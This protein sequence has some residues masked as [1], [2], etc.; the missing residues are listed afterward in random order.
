MSSEYILQRDLK[1]NLHTAVKGEGV[2]IYDESG[3]KYLDGS[4]GAA[5][6][7]LGHSNQKVKDAII[8]Q[9]RSLPYAH[10]SFFTSKPAEELAKMLIQRAP[11]NMGK[12]YFLSGGTEA[13]ET[14]F[15]LIRQY[16]IENKEPQRVHIIARRQSYHGNTITALSVGGN[17]KRK[18]SFLP[19]MS[20]YMHH[21]D[22]VYAYRLKKDDETLEEYGIRAANLLEEKILELGKDS[23]AAFVYEPLVGST[24]GAVAAPLSY[25]KKIREICDKYGVLLMSDEIMCGYGRTGYLFTS[26][27][28]GVKPDLITLAKGIGAGYQP[29]AATLVSKKIYDAI[30]NG[31]G[32]FSHG[33]TYVGHPCSTA[34]GV[35]VLKEIEDNNLLDNVRKMG[36][37]LKGK[38]KSRFASHPYVGDIRG[39]GLFVGVELVKNKETKECFDP[40]LKLFGQIKQTAKDLG[41][42]CYPMGG[43]NFGKEGDHILLAPPFIINE[44][45]IVELIDKL[46]KAINRSLEI[47]GIA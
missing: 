43:T 24:L 41:L 38:L 35:A 6:S 46:E 36:K 9:L 27:Y 8:D 7:C 19:Y 34:A 11:N 20:K 45:Q 21:I 12:V 37:I 18:E 17:V 25:Y 3:K 10:T 29:L 16:H 40:K 32:A 28:T 2:Y 26:E 47:K 13:N 4:C 14:A 22:P 42:L 44:G 31:S 39:K 15:K 33:H 23:V 1:A 30:S 5:V